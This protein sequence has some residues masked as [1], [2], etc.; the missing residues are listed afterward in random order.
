MTTAMPA[1]GLAF[2]RGKRQPGQ[3]SHARC[4]N[5]NGVGFHRVQVASS[6]C[7]IVA[8]FMDVE[9]AAD[10]QAPFNSAAAIDG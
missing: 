10:I 7:G 5:E 1:A 3:H 8:S 6:G 2:L 4:E 9:P